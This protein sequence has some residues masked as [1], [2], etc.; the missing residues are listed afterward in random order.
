MVTVASRGFLGTKR[1]IYSLCVV[2]PNP[3]GKFAG[4]TFQAALDGRRIRWVP[5]SSFTEEDGRALHH[6]VSNAVQVAPRE[7]WDFL[8]RTLV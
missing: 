7:Q 6:V 1:R 2:P 4:P 8:S 3:T 5:V